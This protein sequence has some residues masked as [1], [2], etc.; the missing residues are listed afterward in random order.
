M[1]IMHEKI[2]LLGRS[3]VKVKLQ[4]KP[5]FTYPWHFHSEY[6]LLYVLDGNGTSFV[7][8]NIEEF[9]SGD[10]VLL[11]SNLPHL[12]KSGESYYE[13]DNQN[14]IT[15]VVIQFSNE[16]FKEAILEY[17]EF[18]LI[19]DL[20][21]RSVRGIR[22]NAGFIQ[23]V[24]PQ[25]F[26]VV[27][28]SGFERI[29]HMLK[30]LQELAATKE[31]RLLAGELYEVENHDFNWSVKCYDNNSNEGISNTYNYVALISPSN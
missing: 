6:E 18:H 13:A 24:R 30:L 3:A 31:Y 25:I 17:P 29:M 22:F 5:R 10:M 8:D 15:Y 4:E 11:G 19:K 27:H 26:E 12:W 23:K 7:A 16:F 2:D 9:K 28:S 1:K 14:N 20:L 21:K